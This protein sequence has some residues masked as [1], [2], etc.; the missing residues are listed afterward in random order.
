VF[1]SQRNA[2]QALADVPRGTLAELLDDAKAELP[3]TALDPDPLDFSGEDADI[4]RFRARLA[5]AVARVDKETRSRLDRVDALLGQ[6]DSA[7][8][9]DRVK[10]LQ[11]AARLL[12]GED[13]QLVPRITLPATT[14]A[15]LA[16][17]WQHSSSGNLTQY[18]RETAGRDFPVDDWLHGI[19]RV[20]EKMHDVENS[21]LLCDAVRPT[22]PFGLTPLQLP[23]RAGE[24]WLAL[25]LPPNQ[26]I[27]GERLLYTAHFAVPFDAAQPICGLLVDE[28]TEV[29]P[30]PTETTGIAFHYDRPSCEPPQS[31]LLALPALRTGIWSWDELL[32]AVVDTLEAAKRRAIEP[33]H[34]DATAYGWFLPAT[35]SAY[36]YPEISISNNLLRNV[37]IYADRRTE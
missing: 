23:Y 13:F 9:E 17:A 11:Q 15:E 33:V 35:T 26:E 22:D 28:W 19:A 6:H 5:D 32:G 2:L 30:G 34:V 20:R 18:L 21:V 4:A 12:L 14:G 10:L 31:W 16:N 24:P 8:A 27:E 3:L 1:I 25:E 37:R 7:G 36:T 29:I